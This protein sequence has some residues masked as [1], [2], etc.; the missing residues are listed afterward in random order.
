MK[1]YWASIT[2]SILTVALIFSQ[3]QV[4]AEA[5]TTGIDKAPYQTTVNLPS[6]RVRFSP[7][8]L[9]DLD[10]DPDG[11]LEIVVGTKDG[12]VFAIQG[13]GEILWSYQ[14]AR[15]LNAVAEVATTT[16]IR[17][18]P[19]LADLDGDGWL[20]VVVSV[21]TVNEENEN[22]GVIALDHNGN[23][24]PG[25]PALTLSLADSGITAGVATS[26]AAGDLDNDGLLEIVF[27][28]FDHRVYA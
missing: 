1:R 9:G 22:G 15:A 13:D 24:L 23:L 17:S 14:T 7:S 8:I 26:P 5:D 19:C 20:E 28:A 4:Q 6:D 27:G 2:L 18:A 21:G 25:W 12:W 11:N 16:T 3:N 10:R